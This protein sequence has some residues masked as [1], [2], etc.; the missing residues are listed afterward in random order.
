MNRSQFRRPRDNLSHVE[1]K[2][3]REL[4]SMNYIN[5]KPA[6]KAQL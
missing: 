2:A 1:R 3:L 5:I 4:K 6:D